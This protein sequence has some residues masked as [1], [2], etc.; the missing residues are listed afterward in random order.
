MKCLLIMNPGSRSG[1]SQKLWRFWEAGLAAAG[2]ECERVVTEKPGHAIEIARTATGIDAVVAVGGDGTINEVLDGIMQNPNRTLAMGVLYS[3]TSPDF[4][5]FHRIP[6]E[7]GQALAA[8]LRHQPRP[9]DVVRIDYHDASGQPL[10]AHLGCGCNIGLGAEIAAVANRIRRHLGDMPGTGIATLRAILRC[11]R[12]QLRCEIDGESV[13]LDEVNNLSIL[14]NPFIASG[15]KLK[16][17]LRPDD[18]RMFA[19]GLKRKSR[20]GLL[21]TLPSFY[22]GNAVAS[23]DLWIRQCTRI[24]ISAGQ[25]QEIEFDGDPRGFLPATLCLMPQALNLI[26]GNND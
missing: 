2:V 18:G 15:L 24:T 25:H 1:R 21:G 8:L 11:Q 9:V 13:Q 16:L 4:C 17:D 26:G 5:R 6:T 10:T 20:L 22:T 12:R 23:G 7:P 3:G 19:V 14:K